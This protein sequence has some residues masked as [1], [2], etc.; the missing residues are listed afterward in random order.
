[1]RVLGL[2]NLEKRRLERDLV[3]V[4]QFQKRECKEDADRLFQCFLVTRQEA[5]EKK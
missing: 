5:I 4:Y 2:L 3:N 1:M